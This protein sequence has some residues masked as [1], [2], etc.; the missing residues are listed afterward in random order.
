MP[1]AVYGFVSGLAGG[2]GAPS[3]DWY[4][5]QANAGD[6]LDISLSLP[7]D[8]TGT[9][10]RQLAQCPS[11]RS[12]IP[13]AP[14][15]ARSR[16]RARCHCRPCM[17]GAYE[18]HVLS[19]DNTSTGD[20][21]AERHR[22]YRWSRSVRGHQ[23]RSGPRVRSSM[24][25]SSYTVTFNHP[26]LLTSL[27]ADEFTITT[28][29][30]APR[31]PRATRSTVPSTV[32]FYFD[33]SIFPLGERR[34]SPMSRS[35]DPTAANSRPT[36]AGHR[37]R[38]MGTRVHSYFYFD[39]VAPTIVSSSI[40][41]SVFSPAPATVTEVVDFSETMNTSYI[42]VGL[43]GNYLG[44]FFSPSSEVWQTGPNGPNSELVLT[45]S[46]LPN[47]TY[48]LYLYAGG[49]QDL[50]GNTCKTPTSANFAVAFGSGDVP[51]A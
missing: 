42:D 34:D 46:N 37:S 33:P 41:G 6:S 43:Y 16:A 39:N 5:F 22:Q 7:G 38:R 21:R 25:P 2:T 27:A 49:F 50:V 18:V 10:S 3:Q 29:L 35:L 14:W 32:T 1:V 26:V 12:T 9:T 11:S 28:R 17:T 24:P 8:P 31:M 13:V 51:D 36:S 23:H 45:Y 4:S 20:V 40:D 15:S 47:D 30:R 48:S 44:G 19:A